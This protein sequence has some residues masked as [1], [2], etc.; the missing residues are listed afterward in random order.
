ML[1]PVGVWEKVIAMPTGTTCHEDTG[2][3]ELGGYTQPMSDRRCSTDEHMISSNRAPIVRE[4]QECECLKELINR[5][6]VGELK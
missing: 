2:T 4:A 5:F 1:C 3:Q 6:V